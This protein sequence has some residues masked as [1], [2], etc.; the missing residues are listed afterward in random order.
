MIYNLINAGDLPADV[1]TPTDRRRQRRRIRL[2]TSDVESYLGHVRLT[3]GG[4]PEVPG[5]SLPMKSTS[6][7]WM[8]APRAAKRLGLRLTTLYRIIDAGGLPAYKFG[9]VIRLRTAD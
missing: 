6:E 5:D 4:A 9:R 3:P 8:G 1:T 2:R 7:E